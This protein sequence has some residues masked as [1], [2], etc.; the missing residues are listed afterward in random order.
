MLRL[1]LGRADEKNRGDSPG[2]PLLAV[3]RSPGGPR[4]GVRGAT[5]LGR[6][7]GAGVGALSSG[8]RHPTPH[9][10]SKSRPSAL[11]VVH[12]RDRQVFAFREVAWKE[13]GPLSRRKG[14]E[15][16]HSYVGESAGSV[17]G[18]VLRAL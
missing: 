12:Y 5:T 13:A 6:S 10:L 7:A 17:P 16:E 14:E 18:A 9:S 8:L 11:L 3:A 15:E 2:N 4:A 1:P